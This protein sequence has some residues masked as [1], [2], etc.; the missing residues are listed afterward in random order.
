MQ[1]DILFLNSNPFLVTMIEC[2]DFHPLSL[3][4]FTYLTSAIAPL[5]ST[6]GHREALCLPFP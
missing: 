1:A 3:D 4:S 6:D 2:D 5:P